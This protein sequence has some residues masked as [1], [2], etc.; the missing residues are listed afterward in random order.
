MTRWAVLWSTSTLLACATTAPAPSAQ[1]E[2]GPGSCAR[3]ADLELV[4]ESS[5]GSSDLSA[6]KDA[7]TSQLRR[8]GFHFEPGA[9]E[10]LRLFIVEKPGPAGAPCLEVKGEL[11]RPG[12][13]YLPVTPF[14]AARC[15]PRARTEPNAGAAGDAGSALFAGLVWGITKLAEAAGDPDGD[16]D[17][18]FSLEAR[19]QRLRTLGELLTEVL[20]RVYGVCAPPRPPE[21]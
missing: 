2:R 15:A 5:L 10:S 13:P 21:P 9:A 20:G 14:I 12:A 1:V 17:R 19:S 6:V 7:I 18:A 16:K 8:L 11:V 4:N 3:L